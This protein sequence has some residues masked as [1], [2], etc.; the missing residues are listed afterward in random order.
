MGEILEGEFPPG[1]NLVSIMQRE[2]IIGEARGMLRLL[3]TIEEEIRILHKKL[4]KEK[5][6]DN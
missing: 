4:E 1:G 3:R 2:Q 5:R 6:D